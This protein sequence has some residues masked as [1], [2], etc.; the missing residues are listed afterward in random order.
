MKYHEKKCRITKKKC[1]HQ[2]G[3]FLIRRKHYLDAEAIQ[4]GAKV[5]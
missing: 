5:T 4:G 3:L 2:E 1:K